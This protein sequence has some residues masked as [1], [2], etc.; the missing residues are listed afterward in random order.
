MRLDALLTLAI[1]VAVAGVLLW[2]VLSGKLSERLRARMETV[3]ALT[4]YPLGLVAMTWPNR[5]LITAEPLLFGGF[6]LALVGLI[7]FEVFRIV[8]RRLHAWRA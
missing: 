7:G 6:T 1:P 3:M 5:D 2:V 8:R 4:L